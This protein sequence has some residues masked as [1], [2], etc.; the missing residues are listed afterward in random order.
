MHREKDIKKSAK[1]QIDGCQHFRHTGNK[2][3]IYLFFEIDKIRIEIK[4]KVCPNLIIYFIILILPVTFPNVVIEEALLMHISVVKLCNI[5]Q[6]WAIILT[7]K[8]K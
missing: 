3:T 6:C 1:K 5:F 4:Y 2:T 7:A 8:I